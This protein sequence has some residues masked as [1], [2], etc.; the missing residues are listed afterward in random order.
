MI[1]KC[2]NHQYTYIYIINI[3]N[4]I[5]YTLYIGHMTE[6]LLCNTLYSSLGGIEAVY[7]L[8][9]MGTVWQVRQQKS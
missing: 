9:Y 2:E 4:T 8:I 1:Y 5:I 6:I 3:H 7:I